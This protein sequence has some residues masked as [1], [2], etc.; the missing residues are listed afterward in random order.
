MSPQEQMFFKEA[1]GAEKRMRMMEI[2]KHKT[3]KYG[4]YQKEKNKNRDEI[5]NE[6]GIKVL[7]TQNEEL[8]NIEEVLEKIVYLQNVFPYLIFERADNTLNDWE[9]MIL[10]SLCS[11]NIIANSTFSWWGAYFNN[12]ENQRSRSRPNVSNFLRLR[13]LKDQM[14]LRR[15]PSSLRAFLQPRSWSCQGHAF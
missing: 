12:Y 1:Q 8:Q 7:R 15:C 11:D 5:S 10:M 14:A 9:Q 13:R 4:D 6:L 2:Q 3:I